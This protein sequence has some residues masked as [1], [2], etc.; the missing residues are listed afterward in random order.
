MTLRVKPTEQGMIL[1]MTMILLMI[2]ST[3]LIFQ[4]YVLS[5]SR[6]LYHQAH[7]HLKVWEELEQ[8]AYQLLNQW[9]GDTC[10]GQVGAYGYTIEAL[11]AYPCLKIVKNQ[12]TF[13]SYHGLLTVWRADLATLQLQLRIAIISREG[14]CTQPF[15]RY[16]K[17][18]VLTWKKRILP[19]VPEINKT[20]H[21]EWV[22]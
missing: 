20:A 4:L 2:L 16:L 13:G 5:M 14:V 3:S 19:N 1:L 12:D 11:G 21:S 9:D 10:N 8:F 17:S 22:F 15:V 7:Y 18:P 6:Q